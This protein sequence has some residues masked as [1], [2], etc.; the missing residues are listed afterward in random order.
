MSAANPAGADRTGIWSSYTGTPR[1]VG[2]SY[3]RLLPRYGQRLGWIGFRATLAV[4]AGWTFAAPADLA[5]RLVASDPVTLGFTLSG[6]LLLGYGGYLGLRLLL[7]LAGPRTVSGEVLRHQL[8]QCRQSSDD[9]DARTIPVNFHLVIDDGRA[10]RT[11]AWV[12]PAGLADTCRVGD[13]VSARVR[14]W[15]R[16]VLAVTVQRL[17]EGTDPFDTEVDELPGPA[18]VDPLAPAG[19][20]GALTAP[21]SLA[22]SLLTVGEVGRALGQ[23]VTLR[24]PEPP[25][26]QVQAVQFVGSRGRPVLTLHVLGGWYGRLTLAGAKPG[27]T[28]LP[29]IGAEAYLRPEQAVGRHDDVVLALALDRSEAGHRHRLPEL[30]RTAMSRLSSWPGP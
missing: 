30:L 9:F 24:A 7:D 26:G 1:R 19:G 5:P 28:P 16:R 8:W 23:R 22:G 11:R 29:G 3:P 6:L 13:V 2:V 21:R 4:L 10:D 15:T 18:R 27:G 17:A 20:S 25:D 14:P 12:L